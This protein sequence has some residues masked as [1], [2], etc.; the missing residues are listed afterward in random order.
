M[1]SLGIMDTDELTRVPFIHSGMIKSGTIN[2][3]V[4]YAVVLV[5]TSM[6]P[7]LP[8][9][10]TCCSHLIDLFYFDRLILQ[11][12]LYGSFML[13]FATLYVIMLLPCV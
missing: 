8:L 5:V 9:F 7:V 10:S 11:L 6:C 2:Q 1:I 12:V 13:K 3:S 4:V